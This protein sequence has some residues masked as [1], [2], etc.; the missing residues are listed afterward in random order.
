MAAPATDELGKLIEAA[1]RTKQAAADHVEFDD[2]ELDRAMQGLKRLSPEGVDFAALRALYARTGHTDYKHWPGTD[3]AAAALKSI[4]GKPGDAAFDRMF[5]RVLEDGNFG[6]AEAAAKDRPANHKPWIVLVTGLN[7]IRKTTSVNMPWFKELLREALDFDGET[8]ELPDGQDSFFR[9]LDY[10]VATVALS[11]F[12]ALYATADE[13]GS[14]AIIKAAIFSRYRTLAEMLGVLL[15]R[16]ASARRMN[17][18]VETSGRDIGMY[19]Y[20]EH[21]FPDESYRKLVVNFEINDIGFAERSVDTRMVREMRDGAAALARAAQ[22]PMA[23]VNA[24]AGGP[25]GSAALAGVQADSQRVWKQIVDAGP[26]SVG[27]SWA[28]AGID[29]HADADKPW[30]VRARGAALGSSKSFEFGPPPD[31]ASSYGSDQRNPCIGPD[32]S[33]CAF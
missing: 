4:I 33:A 27:H 13:P 12:E 2:G 23:I 5:E 21:F 22:E 8:A 17:I 3:E 6:G 31:A 7:G 16:E 19:H 29:I 18:M 32:G 15:L 14:Y 11:E 28:K 30:S 1:E 9:Q 10:M 24:N 26:G 25:Y 20:I